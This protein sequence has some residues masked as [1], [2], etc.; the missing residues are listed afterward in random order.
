YRLVIV[1]IMCAMTVPA[2]LGRAGHRVTQRV[3]LT[4][5]ELASGDTLWIPVDSVGAALVEARCEG[6]RWR[7]AY[8]VKPDGSMYYLDVKP[9]SEFADADMDAGKVVVESGVRIGDCDSVMGKHRLSGVDEDVS[10][11]VE[12]GDAETECYAGSRGVKYLCTT[13]A[14][15]LDR[16]CLIASDRVKVKAIIL[17]KYGGNDPVMVSPVDVSRDSLQRRDP[18]IGEWY[19]LDRSNEP[20]KARLGGEYRLRIQPSADAVPGHYDMLY[21]DGARVNASKWKPDM[22][23]GTLAST[24]FQDR[25]LLRW[26]DAEGNM[27]ERDLR[28]EYD[29]A[30]KVLT[31]YFPIQKAMLRFAHR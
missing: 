8:G 20:D 14:R 22:L 7:L 11:V 23:K 1:L 13:E 9:R 26:Y 30:A 31:L 24:Q 25:Y 4:Q 2:A 12:I 16:C 5:C 15:S 29:S 21:I 10:V 6:Q 19:Y 28:A 3:N 27:M 17:E 18:I